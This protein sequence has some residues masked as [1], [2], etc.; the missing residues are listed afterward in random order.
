LKGAVK[1][2]KG[3]EALRRDIMILAL[4]DPSKS[5]WMSLRD[6]GLHEGS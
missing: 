1:G 3:S 5:L 4:E 6:E 2:L